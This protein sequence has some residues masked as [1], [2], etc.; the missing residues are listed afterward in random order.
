MAR[1]RHVDCIKQCPSS[2]AK[3][4]T[5]ARTEFFAFCLIGFVTLST[6]VALTNLPPLH[7][8]F[9]VSGNLIYFSLVTLTTTGYRDYC[10]CP[11]VCAQPC[12]CRGNHWP[13]LSGDF[14]GAP[15]DA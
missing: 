6:P 15:C 7:G 4:E 9:A 10:A 12:Q 8:D 3:R 2:R 11:S 14:A 1:L 5:Y 13:N